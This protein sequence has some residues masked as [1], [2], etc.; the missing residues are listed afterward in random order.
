MGLSP[1]AVRYITFFQVIASP[2][3][4]SLPLIGLNSIGKTK[5]KWKKL[6][7]DRVPFVVGMEVWTEAIVYPENTFP[8]F[9]DRLFVTEP[10]GK[11]TDANVNLFFQE[12]FRDCL[13][14]LF[15]A[16]WMLT[17]SEGSVT[18]ALNFFYSTR[19]NAL[20]YPIV[21][22]FSAKYLLHCYREEY[23]LEEFRQFIP[24]FTI[25]QL[26]AFGQ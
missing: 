7:G 13:G 10:I 6:L 8:N 2:K 4:S 24:D 12:E 1:I 26:K 19:E 23:L 21:Q 14:N 11:A 20:F 15:P 17:G 22:F 25:E 18:T 3:Y 16:Q 5:V 9:L